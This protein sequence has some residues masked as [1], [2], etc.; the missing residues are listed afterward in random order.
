MLGGGDR[1]AEGRVHD[2][3]ALGGGRLDVDIVDANA[4]T[5]DDLEFGRRGDDL[6]RC[7]GG[8][9]H[10]QTV[11]AGNGFLQLLLA[12]TNL[13]VGFDA[14][15]LK[16]GNGGGG[17]LIGNQDAG[18]RKLIPCGVSPAGRGSGW[19]QRGA[20]GAG[21]GKPMTASPGGGVQAALASERLA[22]AKAQ[23]SHGVSA[24][25]SEA[26]TVEPHQIRKC[27]GASRWPATS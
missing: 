3:D 6:L 12:E 5:A 23:S 19:L 13:H 24:S 1:I 7:L 21:A 16:D 4:G 9:T 27:G 14:P 18:H 17:E 2:D 15:S 10:G 25:T 20:R 22:S 8:R 26:S 11:V